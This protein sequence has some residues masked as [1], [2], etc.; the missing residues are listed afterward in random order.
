MIEPRSY[1]SKFPVGFPIENWKPAGTPTRTPIFGSWCRLEP[2][3]GE[4]HGNS[5]FEEFSEDTNAALWTYLPYGPFENVEDFKNWI[6]KN[7]LGSDPLF[8]A[9]IDPHTNR[10]LGVASYLRINQSSGV[11]EVGHINYGPKLQ[12][13]RA[14]TE[15][16]YLMMK[17]AFDDLGY[18]RYEWKCD[19]LNERSRKA[20]VRLGMTFEGLFRQATIYKNRNRDTAWYSI[21]DCEWPQMKNAFEKWLAPGNFLKNGEQIGHLNDFK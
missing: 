14:G 8:H 6:K 15:V 13:S 21:L 5:L 2:L 7:C 11:I 16:M 9:I 12:Q 18:R 20:A 17:H 19:A 3:N 1:R 10:A 4:I